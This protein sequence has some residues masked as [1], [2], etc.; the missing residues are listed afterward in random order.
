MGHLW[1]VGDFFAPGGVMFS[2]YLVDDDTLILEELINMVPWLDNGFEVVG[3]QT[4]PVTALEEIKFLKP[5]VVFCDLKMPVLDGNE[6]IKRLKESGVD[7]E[8]VMISAYDDFE[9]VRTFFQQSGF[10]YILKPVS[11]N[12]IQMVLEG[13]NGKLSKKKPAKSEEPLTENPGFNNLVRFVN[14]RFSEKIT[15]DM[16]SK[17]FGFSKNYICGLF[18]K[19]FNTS[20]TCYLTELRMKHAKELLTDKDM[21]IKEVAVSCG[22]PEYYHFFR[23]FKLY[24]GISPKEM[25]SGMPD[26]GT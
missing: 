14:E 5:D 20:L 10:D 2:V 3:N 26:D 8:F 9:N 12:D 22:Y 19:H 15:L 21:L 13:I 25:Q 16:L 7:A 23:V 18:S 6:L 11:E 4:N 17:K 1:K 24:Y